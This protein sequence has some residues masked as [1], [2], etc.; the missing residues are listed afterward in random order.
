M[1]LIRGWACRRGQLRPAQIWLQTDGQE[2]IPVTCNSHHDGLEA[3]N[4]P[5]QSGF[6]VDPATLPLE[7]A[8]QDVW[9]GFDREGQFRLP[10]QA[11]I[12]LP[13]RAASIRSGSVQVEFGGLLPSTVAMPSS[14]QPM[15]EAAPEDLREHWQALESFRAYL[16]GIEHQLAQ[17]QQRRDLAS[18]VKKPA[19]APRRRWWGLMPGGR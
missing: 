3:M 5:S 7:L 17:M 8:G 13:S 16:D 15:L 14:Y 18:L 4:L 11:P 19:V 9:F 2:P 12:V 1:G 6:V 10:Q